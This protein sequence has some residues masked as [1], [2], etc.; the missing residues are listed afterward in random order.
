MF[1]DHNI[2]VLKLVLIATPLFVG[3]IFYLLANWKQWKLEARRKKVN[4]REYEV[5]IFNYENWNPETDTLNP[6][7]HNAAL[8]IKYQGKMLRMLSSAEK[9]IYLCNC[10]IT[11]KT[12]WK[13]LVAAR[14]RGIDVK[15]IS[16]YD[17]VKK[18]ASIMEIL[19]IMGKFTCAFAI[20][21]IYRR[22]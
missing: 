16:D 12:M 3:S 2:P 1:S 9:S 5:V 4:E 11:L 15:V 7:L 6:R 22:M 8:K 21:T 14:N 19:H 20:E 10:H 13:V 18:T 17:M